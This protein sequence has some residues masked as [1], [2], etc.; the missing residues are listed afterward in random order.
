MKIMNKILNNFFTKKKDLPTSFM[1]AMFTR[2][3]A[4][5]MSMIEELLNLIGYIPYMN[6]FECHIEDRQVLK[7]PYVN[8]DNLKKLLDKN[9]KQLTSKSLIIKD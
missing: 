2:R 4:F 1:V 9:I 5:K 6:R 7:L 3:M 8:R